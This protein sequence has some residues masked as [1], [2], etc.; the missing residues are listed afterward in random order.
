MDLPAALQQGVPAMTNSMSSGAPTAMA[1]WQSINRSW[2]AGEEDSEVCFGSPLTPASPVGRESS[3]PSGI[4]KAV[5]GSR[6]VAAVP[7]LRERLGSGRRPESHNAGAIKLH[8][9]SVGGLVGSK[10]DFCSTASSRLV[11]SIAGRFQAP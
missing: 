11:S 6:V 4:A 5:G 8:R 2:H 3:L 7:L 10:D 9:L 1:V